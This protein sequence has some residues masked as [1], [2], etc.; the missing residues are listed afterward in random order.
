MA[1]NDFNTNALDEVNVHHL[2]RQIHNIADILAGTKDDG[3]DVPVDMEVAGLES[4][5][6]L[7]GRAAEETMLSDDPVVTIQI[8]AQAHMMIAA[9][10]TG[11]ILPSSGYHL[12]ED[13]VSQAEKRL[14]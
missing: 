14:Q 6:K 7:A 1:E 4:I 2:F 10:E 9:A 5:I 8:P 12:L 13:L 11:M 3:C